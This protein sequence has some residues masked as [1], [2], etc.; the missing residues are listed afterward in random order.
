[1]ESRGGSSPDGS[2]CRCVIGL[3]P[4][5][6]QCGLSGPQ[7]P[8]ASPKVRELTKSQG[9]N[10]LPW[11]APALRTCPYPLVLS[12]G[13]RS[14]VSRG[15]VRDAPFQALSHAC[16]ARI[17]AGGLQQSVLTSLPGDPSAG[18]SGRTTALLKNIICSAP[19]NQVESASRGKEHPKRGF[20]VRLPGSDY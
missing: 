7:Q 16:R 8:S 6:F 2:R 18:S 5:E 3:L 13:S 19:L 4:W 20:P 11:R 17:S 12:A 15:R 9:L 1:M 14:S 10:H